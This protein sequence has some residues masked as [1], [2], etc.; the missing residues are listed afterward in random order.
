MLVYI[1]CVSV[2]SVIDITLTYMKGRSD[3]TIKNNEKSYKM[4]M[5]YIF[6][7]YVLQRKE[8]NLLR[9]RSFLLESVLASQF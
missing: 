9:T 5:T 7:M 8:Q 6:W 3:F 1:L 4:Q 2:N